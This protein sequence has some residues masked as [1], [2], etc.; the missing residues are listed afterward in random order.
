MYDVCVGRFYT[1]FSEDEVSVGR[2]L[3]NSFLNS[4]I[5]I[6]VIVVMTI[7]LVMLYK[8]RCYKVTSCLRIYNKLY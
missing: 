7:F 3:L 5:M 2:R 4:I 8:Y 6:S 1:P